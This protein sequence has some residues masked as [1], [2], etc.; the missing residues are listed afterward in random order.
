[1]TTSTLKCLSN[2]A[3]FPGQSFEP[4]EVGEHTTVQAH[5]HILNPLHPS[6]RILGPHAK[7]RCYGQPAHCV[8]PGIGKG[9]LLAQSFW[10]RPSVKPS[11]TSL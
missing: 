3:P 8:R 9:E 2:Q 7:G 6:L 5:H 4:P 10:E 11:L 1:M